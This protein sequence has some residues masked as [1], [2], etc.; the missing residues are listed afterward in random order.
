L[1]FEVEARTPLIVN[2]VAD[3]VH[4]FKPR[5]SRPAAFLHFS[6][7]GQL[8][9]IAVAALSAATILALAERRFP[10]DE[11]QTAEI[12]RTLDST[13]ALARAGALST[14]R[15]SLRELELKRAV[16]AFK[17]KSTK[18]SLWSPDAFQADQR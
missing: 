18:Q 17:E 7:A 5:Q 16:K 12:I 2:V 11:D 8:I 13:W 14:T 15:H 9:S 4:R 6:D 1:R 3:R 10:T